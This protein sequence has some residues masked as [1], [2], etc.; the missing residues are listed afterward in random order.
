MQFEKHQHRSAGDRFGHRVDAKNR[1]RRHRCAGVN[2]GHPDLFEM[3]NL[4]APRN[5]AADASQ[6]LFIDIGL[7]FGVDARQP[8]AI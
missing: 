3:D 6:L 1:F 7:H 8:A 2:I 5:Q 4:A